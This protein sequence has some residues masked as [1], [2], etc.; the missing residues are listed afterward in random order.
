M[1]DRLV[2]VPQVAAMLAGSASVVQPGEEL[3]EIE[4]KGLQGKLNIYVKNNMETGVIDTL[5]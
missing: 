3:S 1:I 2:A 4:K 5:R